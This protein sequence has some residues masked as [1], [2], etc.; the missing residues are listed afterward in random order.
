[1]KILASS[2]GSIFSIDGKVRQLDFEI[3]TPMP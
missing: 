3:R 2:I 1:M